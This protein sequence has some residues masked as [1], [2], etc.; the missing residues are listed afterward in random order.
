VCQSRDAASRAAL[1]TT[2]TSSTI[3]G[4]LTATV[5]DCLP[6]NRPNAESNFA[7]AEVATRFG[8]PSMD[9]LPPRNRYRVFRAKA[10]RFNL[11]HRNDH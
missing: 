1:V 5:K 4:P 3:S 9:R 7:E 6:L 10:Q 8:A 11:S 2:A